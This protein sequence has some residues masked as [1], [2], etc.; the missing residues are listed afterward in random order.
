MSF[1]ESVAVMCA[2]AAAIFLVGLVAVHFSVPRSFRGSLWQTFW[3]AAVRG[4]RQGLE[5]PP[6]STARA[7]EP[8]QF[9][10]LAPPM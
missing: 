4:D 7:G 8:S 9:Q 6:T 3:L 10:T 1:A 2:C 5:S